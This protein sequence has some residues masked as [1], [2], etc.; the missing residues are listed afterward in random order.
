MDAA[1]EELGVAIETEPIE[2]AVS[3]IEFQTHVLWQVP[4]DLGS[5]P[6]EGASAHIF[7]IEI[8]VRVSS[9]ARKPVLPRR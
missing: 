5:D 3:I 8:D 6:V 9:A 1:L 7:A 2:M 4:I